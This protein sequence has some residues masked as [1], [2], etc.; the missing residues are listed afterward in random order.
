MAFDFLKNSYL[1]RKQGT[2]LAGMVILITLIALSGVLI[3]KLTSALEEAY[4]IE[5]R[6]EVNTSFNK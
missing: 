4:Y 6:V 2:L 5:S 1:Q 3:G